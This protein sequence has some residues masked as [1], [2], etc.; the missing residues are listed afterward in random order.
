MFD[1]TKSIILN[2]FLCFFYL[3]P[4]PLHLSTP[5]PSSSLSTTSFSSSYFLNSLYSSTSSLSSFASVVLIFSSSS[6]PPS[7]SR[8]TH[9]CIRILSKTSLPCLILKLNKS[10]TLLLL[11]LYLTH[12]VRN[13]KI[14]TYDL[15]VPLKPFNV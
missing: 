13:Y 8:Y 14:Q 4:P 1:M 7:A 10:L 6:P 9:S 3:F 2:V 11:M 5:L 15:R 12:V